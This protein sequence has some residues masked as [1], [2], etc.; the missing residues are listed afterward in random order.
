MLTGGQ[1]WSQAGVQRLARIAFDGLPSEDMAI[2]KRDQRLPGLAMVLNV[3]AASELIGRSMALGYLRYKPGESCTAWVFDPRNPLD[4]GIVLR[5]VTSDRHEIYRQREEW[6]GRNDVLLLEE[7]CL[8]L[9]PPALDRKVKAA[10]QL[11]RPGGWSTLLGIETGAEHHILRFKP[12]RRLVLK[13]ASLPLMIRATTRDRY[14]R[15]LRGAEFG[16]ALGGSKVVAKNSRK[17][18]FATEWLPG[19]T[20][21]PAIKLHDED[22]YRAIGKYLACLHSRAAELDEL[23]DCTLSSADAALSDL[24]VLLPEMG[25]TV[26]DLSARLQV[27][28]SRLRSKKG[29]C[30]GDFS[31]DQVLLTDAGIRVIDWDQF[32][33]GDT[34][35]DLGSFLARIDMQ[36]LAG[37]IDRDAG[38]ITSAAFLEGYSA[39]REVPSAALATHHAF[40]L[41]ALATEPFRQRAAN[42]AGTT[43][44]LLRRV[45]VLLGGSRV[46]VAAGK[47]ASGEGRLLRCATDLGAMQKLLATHLGGDVQMQAADLIRHKPGRRALVRYKG[48]LTSSEGRT[49]FDLIGKIRIKGPDRRTPELHRVLYGLAD[50][51]PVPACRAEI[52]HLSMWLQDHV[53]GRVLT[54]L[55]NADDTTPFHKAGEALARL[56]ETMPLPDRDWTLDDEK[57]VLI[58]ALAKA[59]IDRADLAARIDAVRDRLVSDLESLPEAP[60]CSIHRDF[61]PDQVVVGTDR[62]WLLDLDL[63]A[64]GDPAIDVGN[65]LAHLDEHALRKGGNPEGYGMHTAAF[66][67]GYASHRILPPEMRVDTLR[68]FSLARHI[69][70]SL[71]FPDRFASAPN[72]LAHLAAA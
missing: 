69:G 65:F 49:P 45:D 8:T 19:Q 43:K 25:R 3:A 17:A 24:V 27:A 56:H 63:C 44:E 18:V 70:I 9:L 71:R 2:V 26:A 59:E 32:G 51:P 38:D 4:A 62:V 55:L 20:A 42:W 28:G 35:A 66:L 50:A 31:A 14:E 22:V 40:A 47:A 60:V 58:S 64:I 5:S 57:N 54:D 15:A 46:E 21:D 67:R 37:E 10:C 12:E 48:V 72:I 41:A 16:A 34:T 61:Y 23:S 30:H 52:P 11:E 36:V 7:L 39:E 13:D 53:P 1:Y 29:L 33:L 68:R 6:Q